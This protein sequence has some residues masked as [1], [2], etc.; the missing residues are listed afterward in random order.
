M[1]PFTWARGAP[2]ECQISLFRVQRFQLG[3]KKRGGA[4]PGLTQSLLPREVTPHKSIAGA[5]HAWG[6][7]LAFCLGASWRPR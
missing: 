2:G 6:R 7:R 1:Q 3:A 5:G 4:T